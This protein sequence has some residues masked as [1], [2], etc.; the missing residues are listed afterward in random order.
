M[1]GHAYRAANNDRLPVSDNSDVL[2]VAILGAGFAG[3]CMAAQL[4]RAGRHN[5]KV[6]ERANRIGGTWRDNT[7]P[8]CACDIPSLLYSY[9]FAPRFRWSRAYPQQ[10]EIWRYLS[11]FVEQ[12]GLAKHLQFACDVRIATYDEDSAIWILECV[13][14]QV[15]RSKVVVLG[16][17][18]LNRPNIPKL[19]GA[20][21]FRGFSFHSS[22]WDHGVDAR[23]KRVAVIGTGASAIQI[24]P[25]LAKIASH[26]TVFQRT[27]AWIVAKADRALLSSEIESRDRR[28]FAQRMRRWVIY[29]RQEFLA[30]GFTV[31]P[32]L[33]KSAENAAL[34]HMRSV[35]GSEDMQKKLTPG[36]PMGCKRILISNDFY[37]AL[38]NQNVALDANGVVAIDTTGV[39]TADGRHVEV[40]GI[41]YA[42]GFKT[43]EMLGD[44]TVLGVAGRSLKDAWRER[45]LAYLGIAVHGFPN[46]FLLVGPNT[47][48]GHN[49]IVFMIEA[50]VHYVMQAL[51][52]L[53]RAAAKSIEVRED[54]V[55]RFAVFLK[56]RLSRTIWSRGCSSWYLDDRQ[57]NFTL[58]PGF[59]AEYWLRTRWLQRRHFIFQK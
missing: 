16:M 30:F 48:L 40:D 55:T 56:R 41:I 28:P 51:K 4:K 22:R 45:V 50:Q 20:E 7:Y 52:A 34:M 24:V 27:A 14:G 12:T 29:W 37:P 9:S 21:T 15:L 36:Y 42:T 8:G 26:L 3:L 38:L 39:V 10:D 59:S 23:N 53:D 43:M 17:G 54:A 32:R 44:T 47:G 19:P 6:L 13:D 58:W 35:I 1:W 57:Q 31:A 11:Q 25:E 33:M 5:F 18:G 2:D 46:L 49:S